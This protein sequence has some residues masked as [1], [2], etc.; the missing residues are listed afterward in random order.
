MLAWLKYQFPC[1]LSAES[2]SMLLKAVCIPWLGPGSSI[3]ASS[4]VLSLS[5]STFFL[6]FSSVFI[7][8]V[9]TL[10]SR[11]S[12]IISSFEGQLM[13]NLSSICKVHFARKVTYSQILGNRTWIF[14]VIQ[15]LSTTEINFL[16]IYKLLKLTQEEK[17]P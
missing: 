13:T 6:S 16:K 7:T 15:F 11:N 10:S 3:K 1:W 12:L 8:H 4:N 14:L 9:I 2:Y 17:I 5:H